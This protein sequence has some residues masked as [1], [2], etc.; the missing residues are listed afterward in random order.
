MFFINQDIP[1]MI[2]FSFCFDVLFAFVVSITNIPPLI[3][4]RKHKKT[5][6]IVLITFLSMLLLWL[7]LLF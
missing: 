4:S 1:S 2:T 5:I 7:F 3:A 6:F